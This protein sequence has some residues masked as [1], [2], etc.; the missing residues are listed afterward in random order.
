MSGLGGGKGTRTPDFYNANVALYQ[1]S[2]TP[3]RLT[4]EIIPAVYEVRKS[5]RG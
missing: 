3:E 5:Q 4:G 2:Y 1:L